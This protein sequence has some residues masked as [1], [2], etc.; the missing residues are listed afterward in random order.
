MGFFSSIADAFSKNGAVTKFCE[1]IPV[2]GHV[3]A[4]IQAIAGNTE[5]AK[6]ALATSTG[7]LVS[8]VGAVGGFVVGGP[9]GAVAGGALGGLAGTYVE[10]GIAGSINDPSVKGDLGHVTAG[11][12]ITNMGLGGASAMF[13]GGGGLLKSGGTALGKEVMKGAAKI[14]AG[15]AIGQGLKGL[16]PGVETGDQDET[17]PKKRRYVSQINKTKSDA[18][19]TQMYAMAAKYPVTPVSGPC[20]NAA[21]QLLGGITV[22]QFLEL[23]TAQFTQA[24]VFFSDRFDVGGAN[25]QGGIPRAVIDLMNQGGTIVENGVNVTKTADEIRTLLQADYVAL[26]NLKVIAAHSFEYEF[27]ER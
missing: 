6:R 22:G 18:C 10:S 20:T 27:D 26:L 1:Q 14:G 23:G 7:N 4:G 17:G 21:V 16:K 11:K 19:A 15:S 24:L 2:V 3:T 9:P 5:E 8:T 12:V 13:G 25:S